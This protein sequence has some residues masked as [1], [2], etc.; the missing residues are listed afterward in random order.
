MPAEANRT[1]PALTAALQSGTN[2]TIHS[3]GPVAFG[4]QGQAAC[5][6]TSDG[7]PTKGQL[8]IGRSPQPAR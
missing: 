1:P 2:V 5:G 6:T 3:L 7:I 4:L 8:P